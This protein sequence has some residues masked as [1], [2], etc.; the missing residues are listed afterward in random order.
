MAVIAF[1]T[2]KVIRRLKESGMPEPQ[3]EAIADAFK[4]AQSEAEFATKQDIAELKQEMVLPLASPKARRKSKLLCSRRRAA[5]RQPP[6]KIWKI[7]KTPC[8]RT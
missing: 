1:D 5:P 2:D 6:G 4:D 8:G 3:A 7:P